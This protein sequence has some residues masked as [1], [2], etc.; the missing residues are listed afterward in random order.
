MQGGA[1]WTCPG[2]MFNF[3]DDLFQVERPTVDGRVSTGRRGSAKQTRGMF[4]G[5]G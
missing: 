4:D 5:N 2:Q 3:L 1:V